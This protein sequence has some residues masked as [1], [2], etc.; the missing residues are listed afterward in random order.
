MK[1]SHDWENDPKLRLVALCCR[2]LDDKKAENIRILD[3]S[4]IS[5]ITD[6]F[7]IATGTSDPHLKSLTQET[8][9]VLKEDKQHVVGTETGTQSGWTVLDAHDVIV[10]LFLPEM[11][12]LYRLDALWKD[13]KDLPLD[14][15][16]KAPEPLGRQRGH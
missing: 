16:V 6:F 10:H 3:V 5:S 15:F 9:R 8:A 2:A 4:K 7:I 12:D 11:R 14:Q 1:K 13:G